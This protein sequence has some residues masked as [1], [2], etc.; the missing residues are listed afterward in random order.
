[1]SQEELLAKIDP[2]LWKFL[3]EDEHNRLQ[4][5]MRDN[6]EFLAEVVK[7]KLEH[8]VIKQM[9]R[10]ALQE[11]MKQWDAEK[12][13]ETASEVE[14]EQPSEAGT[15]THE[16]P[17]IA[18]PVV[19]RLV[20]SRRL[21]YWAMAASFTLLV[22]FYW[23]KTN[24]DG[25]KV[26]NSFY[27]TLDAMPKDDDIITGGI[28]QISD[29]E[30]AE[31]AYK[32]NDFEGMIVI[33]KKKLTE[34]AKNTEG[35]LFDKKIEQ[36]TEWRLILAYLAAKQSDNTELNALLKKKVENPDHLYHQEAV[37]LNKK[38]NSFWWRLV[39]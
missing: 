36:Y 14:D 25:V 1:M 35:S 13:S 24:N 7:R 12:K 38:I 31:K 23:I 11:K 6:P 3:P 17:Q 29:F 8:E 26:S 10:D 19:K 15:S 39:N 28:G 20:P 16:I 22:S 32:S 4:Q 5:E 37:E 27:V 34:I 33:Y 18:P 21:M 9:K 30:L 2:F